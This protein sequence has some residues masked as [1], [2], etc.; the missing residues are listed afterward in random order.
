MQ[1]WL[2]LAIGAFAAS[3]GVVAFVYA[4]FLAYRTA[5]EITRADR[6]STAAASRTGQQPPPNANTR[7][8][9]VQLLL[10]RFALLYVVLVAWGF[11]AGPMPSASPS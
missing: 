4:R 2:Q 10:V 6:G 3:V 9:A 7:I 5:Q 1:S 8:F 11:I